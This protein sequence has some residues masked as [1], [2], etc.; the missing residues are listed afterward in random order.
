L[1]DALDGLYFDY[2]DIGYDYDSI[3]ID[4]LDQWLDKAQNH[5]KQNN[6]KEA[7]LICKACIEEYAAWYEESDCEVLDYIDPAYHRPLRSK[8]RT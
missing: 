6:P 1:Q 5:V 3:E 7:I 4:V 8:Y 2:E